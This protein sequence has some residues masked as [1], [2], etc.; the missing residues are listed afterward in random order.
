MHGTARPQP[1]LQLSAE[2]T[3]E[4]VLEQEQDIG[5]RELYKEHFPGL[6]KDIRENPD[7]FRERLTYRGAGYLNYLMTLDEMKVVVED[8][9][10]Q[11]RRNGQILT[12]D[13]FKQRD[14]AEWYYKGDELTRIWGAEYLAEKFAEAGE[15][16]FKVPEYI[17]VVDDPENIQ[18]DIWFTDCFPVMNKIKNSTIYAEYIRGDGAAHQLQEE[19]AEKKLSPL[20]RRRR[21]GLFKLA[22][23]YTDFSGNNN[24]LRTIEGDNYFVD[25]AWDS[26]YNMDP[27][28]NIVPT[29]FL[30]RYVQKR[31]ETFNHVDKTSLDTTTF[32]FS[33]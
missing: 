19:L 31:F 28:P 25:T 12:K 3:V 23:G 21:T 11:M 9:F 8:K 27:G 17:I 2:E 26:F 10:K 4:R 15:P 33:L 7:L 14:S 22:H 13:E 24:I 16:K 29:R 20:E 1:P 30:C 5:L 32:E 6:E 18:A